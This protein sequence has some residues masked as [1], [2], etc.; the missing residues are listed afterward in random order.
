MLHLFL[1]LFKVTEQKISDPLVIMIAKKIQF[2][3]EL[4]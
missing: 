4:V 2:F 3:A 1:A